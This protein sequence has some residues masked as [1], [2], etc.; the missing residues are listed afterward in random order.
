MLTRLKECR[1]IIFRCAFDLLIRININIYGLFMVY[2]FINKMR[3]SVK[4]N[5]SDG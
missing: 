4:I 5:D 1:I 2:F 3:A